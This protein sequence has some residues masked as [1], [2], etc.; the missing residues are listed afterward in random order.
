MVEERVA[1]SEEVERSL[2]ALYCNDPLGLLVFITA[3]RK[4]GH[5]PSK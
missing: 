5:T 1:I 3:A 4:N 2:V